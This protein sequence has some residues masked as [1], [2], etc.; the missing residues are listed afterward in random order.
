MFSPSPRRRRAI[1]SACLAVFLPVSAVAYWDGTV[2]DPWNFVENVRQTLALVQQIERAVRQI[3]QQR[4][5]LRNLPE[6]VRDEM[7]R[8]HALFYWEQLEHY[9]V[10]TSPHAIDAEQDLERKYPLEAASEAGWLETRRREWAAKRRMD[11]AEQREIQNAAYR[12]MQPTSE[13]VARIVTASNAAGG[14]GD[15]GITATIQAQNELLASLST[16]T[17]KLT[18]LRAVR[19]RMRHEA[20]AREQSEA[21]YQSVRRAVLMRDWQ[22]R[23]RNP[24]PRPFGRS[25]R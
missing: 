16:E 2:Y 21:A 13:R 24:A 9:G 17:N 19:A 20:T 3:Q 18:A 22:Q 15:T 1:V 5:M 8:G 11:L 4:Q 7:I 12:D 23:S 14:N 6:S 25:P 10:Y